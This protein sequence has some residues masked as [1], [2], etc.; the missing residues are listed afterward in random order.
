MDQGEGRGMVRG[1][2]RPAQGSWEMPGLRVEADWDCGWG[3]DS[4]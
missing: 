4:I 1:M 2:L 3:S